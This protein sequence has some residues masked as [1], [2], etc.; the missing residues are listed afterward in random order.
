MDNDKDRVVITGTGI[1]SPLGLDTRTTWEGLIAGESGIDY[2]TL[3]DPSDMAAKFAGEVKGFQPTDYMERKEA[4]RM[5]RFAQL[6]VAASREAVES[7]RLEIDH[8]NDDDIGVIIGSGIGGLTTLFEQAKVLVEKGPDRV[9]PFL[10][11]MMIAD[12]A[13]AQVS[14]ALGVKGPNFCTTSACSSGSDA[15]GAAY[16]LIRHGDAQV[17]LAGGTEALI[18]PLGITAFTALKALSTRNE[19][20]KKASRPFDAERDGFV[21]S[22][23]ACVLILEKLEHALKRGVPV[24]AEIAAYGATA[25]SFHVTQPMENGEGAARAIRIALKKANIAPTDIDYINAHGTSTQLND[26]M[27]TRAI[28]TVFGDYAYRV[29][30][31]STKSMLGHLIGCAGAAEAMVCILSILN[32]IIPPTINY[33]HPDPDC[34]LDYVPNV[35]R[36]AEVKTALSSSFGFG[37]HNS[38]LILRRYTEA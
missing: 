36:K 18:N 25:D 7:A 1:L 17:M 2:I 34:D 3:F 13:A 16:E 23:G 32:G 10:A 27:E 38:V 19:A 31:S 15:I 9:S 4:R 5:D 28:K 20:P 37:G 21:I 8:T 22:E 35:A 29:P 26:V 33:D 24:L 6:A 14:I 30:I 11:P 12:I